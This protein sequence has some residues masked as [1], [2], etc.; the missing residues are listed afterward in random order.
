[1]SSSWNSCQDRPDHSIKQRHTADNKAASPAF[2]H[3]LIAD[4]LAGV[5]MPLD[6]KFVFR[7]LPGSPATIF[8][9]SRRM[10]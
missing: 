7:G 3:Q 9:L 2:I 4:V 6:D 5:M 1:M 10:A 8:E